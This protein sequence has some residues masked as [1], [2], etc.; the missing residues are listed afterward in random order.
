MERSLKVQLL[1]HTPRP[2]ETAALAGRRCYSGLDNENLIASS[3]EK[4]PAAFIEKLV[5]MGHVTPIEHASFTFAVEGVSRSLLAQITRHRLASFSVQSQRYVGETAS[6]NEDGI[7]D[8]IV[9]PRIAELGPEQ[10]AE[11]KRQ[12]RQIQKWYDYWVD[13]LGGDRDAYEDARFVL[14]NAAETKF[15]FTM[16]AREL[17]HFFTLRCCDRAQ[18]EIRNLADEMLLLVKKVAPAI[19]AKAG[20]ACLRGP[21][22]EGK[23]NCGKI[24]EIREKYRSFGNEIS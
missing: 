7:F 2:E 4:D 12:M 3:R 13:L 23:L 19:F 9:P 8:Y 16:N 21:C 22:P 18:W 1:C 11:F 15:V 17:L 10:V 20:P 14:P 6:Q 24:N 5:N